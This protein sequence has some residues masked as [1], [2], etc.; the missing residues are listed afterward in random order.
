MLN[1]KAQVEDNLEFVLCIIALV[2]GVVILTLFKADY[3]WSIEQA[4][5]HLKTGVDIQ[6]FDVQFM[7][8]DLL[9]T[10]KLPSGE[11]T[12]AELI[13]YMPRNYQEIED[14]ALFEDIFWDKWFTEGIACDTELYTP[15][16]SY[17]SPV[18]GKYWE[19]TV[20]YQEQ[21]IFICH[22]PDILYGFGPQQTNM[23]LPTANPNEE[24]IVRL[25]VFQ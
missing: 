24:V 13:S 18:Y 1:K 7:G 8:T 2:I 9:N 6:S 4:K 20:F 25:E 21:E 11:Y 14:P 10:L 3:A 23:T 12:F 16:N 19:I 17:L 15:I 22:P 5:S